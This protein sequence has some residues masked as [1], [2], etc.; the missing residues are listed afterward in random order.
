MFP[1]IISNDGV[2]VI[3]NGKPRMVPAS[4]GNYQPLV[5][6]INA[7]DMDEVAMLSD[8]KAAVAVKTF[9]RV[10]IL[11]NEVEVDG[12]VISGR[13]V[14]RILEMV[15]L[16]SEA[17]EGYVAFLD[18]LMDNPRKLA[19][20]EL[21]L[22]MEACNLPVTSDGHLLAYRYVRDD[23]FDSYSRTTFAKPADAMTS[24]ELAKY[25]KPVI[26]GRENEVTT[27]VIDGITNVSMPRN[28]VDDVRDRTCS[29]GLHFCSYNY[30][31]S[32]GIGDTT[33]VLIVK[34]NPADVVS[35]PSDYNNA[36]G[37]TCKYQV[38]SE[39][40][41]WEDTR[42]T[43]W[44]TDEFEDDDDLDFDPDTGE[45]FDDEFGDEEDSL[46]DFDPIMETVYDG[47][48]SQKL[49]WDEVRDMRELFDEGDL[50]LKRI[51]EMY[52]ISR[53]Q[54]ARIRDNESWIEDNDS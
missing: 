34:I 37:R 36:K 54:A 2:T 15:R 7:G 27:Q 38:V 4:H 12:R 8:I 47:D 44:F 53:R 17:L 6:A 52:G 35:I 49:T 9:G 33:R 39:I 23:Y 19:V 14:D 26:G 11:D 50:T 43:P 45:I 5:D 24:E 10:K 22:F 25:S 3:V 51:A 31:P 13:L 30:L 48:Y 16:G 46:N 1:H 32:Y 20:D 40:E 42:I 18:N 29:Q 21:Y 41:N 28:M